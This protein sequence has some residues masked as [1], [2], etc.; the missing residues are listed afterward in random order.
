MFLPMDFVFEYLIEHVTFGLKH[1]V[2]ILDFLQGYYTGE[3]QTSQL[4]VRSMFGAV[5]HSLASCILVHSLE[6]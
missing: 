5:D 4:I 2:S 3:F 1:Q 6:I